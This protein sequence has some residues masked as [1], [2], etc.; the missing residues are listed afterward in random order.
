MQTGAIQGVSLVTGPAK[1]P[2]PAGQDERLRPGHV[3]AEESLGFGKEG[4]EQS[5]G[6]TAEEDPEQDKPA[7][8]PVDE[9][10]QR[11]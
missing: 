7:E 9:T 8:G 6:R 10:D 5:H 11:Y 1:N 4:E 3:C 2:V